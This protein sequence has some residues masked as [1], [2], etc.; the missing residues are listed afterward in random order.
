MR[1][2]SHVVNAESFMS[3]ALFSSVSSRPAGR[4]CLQSPIHSGKLPFA[5]A[6]MWELNT[7]GK[8]ILDKKSGTVFL[9]EQAQVDGMKWRKLGQ[10]DFFI[11]GKL[12]NGQPVLIEAPFDQLGARAKTDQL[13]V[14]NILG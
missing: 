13:Q 6:T 14:L 12:L 1:F 3:I 10:A 2:C 5:S 8:P 9:F 4:Q 7:S 11:Q